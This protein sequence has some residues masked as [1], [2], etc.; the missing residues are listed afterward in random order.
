MPTNHQITT[1]LPPSLPFLSTTALLQQFAASSELE[2]IF[3]KPE[4]VRRLLD[5]VPFFKALKGIEDIEQKAVK[6]ITSE[7]VSVVNRHIVAADR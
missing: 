4:H 7:D 5:G 1:S 6:D 2:S 3:T